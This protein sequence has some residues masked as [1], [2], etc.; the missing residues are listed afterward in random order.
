MILRRPC[1][2]Q[3]RRWP[4]ERRSSRTFRA[5]RHPAVL[6]TSTGRHLPRSDMGV[7]SQIEASDGR[8]R[9][10][11]RYHP[12]R[13]WGWVVIPR[14]RRWFLRN[15]GSRL[16]LSTQERGSRA[17]LAPSQNESPHRKVRHSRP[18]AAVPGR[19]ARICAGTRTGAP[20]GQSGGDVHLAGCADPWRHKQTH[21]LISQQRESNPLVSRTTGASRPTLRPIF[22]PWWRDSRRCLYHSASAWPTDRERSPPGCGSSKIYRMS[23]CCCSESGRARPTGERCQPAPM[24]R[25]FGF[26][27]CTS[28]L[29]QCTREDD[30]EPGATLRRRHS[31]TQPIEAKRTARGRLWVE[32]GYR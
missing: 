31:A 24:N 25:T 15:Y 14:S 5:P 10:L 16:P 2:T 11:R 26:E 20:S 4:P 7:T 21:P 27:A 19:A 23:C 13:S 22:D 6:R 9:H 1:S 18:Y 29:R 30:A 28:H 32:P 8:C 12:P 3:S 17:H